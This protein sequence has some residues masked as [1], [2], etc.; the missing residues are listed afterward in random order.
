MALR[1]VR[2]WIDLH[3]AVANCLLAL[4]FLQLLVAALHLPLL[5]F[6]ARVIKTPVDQANPSSPAVAIMPS[7][8]RQVC[9]RL[10]G[11]PTV[12][13]SIKAK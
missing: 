8:R 9:G 6:C 13:Y 11:L 10:S 7:S 3:D 2:E 12:V 5:K 1:L 4:L